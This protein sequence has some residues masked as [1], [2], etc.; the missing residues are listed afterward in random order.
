MPATLETLGPKASLYPEARVVLHDDDVH[1]MSEVV[2][3]L[4]E[5][6]PQL[7]RERCVAIM[8]EAHRLGMA[9]VLEAPLEHAEGYAERLLLRGLQV[10]VEAA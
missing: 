9:T 2:R 8:L 3:Y 10:T 7:G 6:V 4:T 5:A 1:E